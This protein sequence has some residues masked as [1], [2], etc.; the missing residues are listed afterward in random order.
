M[1][2]LHLPPG[3]LWRTAVRAAALAALLTAFVL[4]AAESVGP[5]DTSSAGGVATT[6]VA[7]AEPVRPPLAPRTVFNTPLQSPLAQLGAP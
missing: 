6:A 5:G 4:L 1:H 2:V 7:P 3:H